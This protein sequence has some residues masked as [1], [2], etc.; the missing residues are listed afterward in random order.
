MPNKSSST[1]SRDAFKGHWLRA[2]RHGFHC[3]AKT[4]MSRHIQLRMV[5]LPGP[6]EAMRSD[7]GA[8]GFD[9]YRAT[10]DRQRALTGS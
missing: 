3:Y 7:F 6:V 2:I 4:R 9:L 10:S 8:V 1:K 5:D